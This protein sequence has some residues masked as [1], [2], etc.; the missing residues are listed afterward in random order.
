MGLKD[1]NMALR[2]IKN[3]IKEFG[4]DNTKITLMG[5]SAGEKLDTKSRYEF[6]IIL[7]T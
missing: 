4:G 5:E 2:F 7:H 3:N 6:Q 1:Q